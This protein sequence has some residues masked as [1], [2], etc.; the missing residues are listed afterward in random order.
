MSA[1]IEKFLVV[2]AAVSALVLAGIHLAW[3]GELAK[4]QSRLDVSTLV[5]RQAV[6]DCIAEVNVCAKAD[7]LGSHVEEDSAAV[8][9]ATKQAWLFLALSIGVPCALLTMRMGVRRLTRSG[10]H[11]AS[12]ATTPSG[13]APASAVPDRRTARGAW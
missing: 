8:E 5:H 2:A 3:Q 4:L 13:D 6:S 7:Y 11:Q 1:R 9:D 10:Q 12:G